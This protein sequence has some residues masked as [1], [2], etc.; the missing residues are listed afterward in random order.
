M[1][2]PFDAANRLAKAGV[3]VFYLELPP[4]V[5]GVSYRVLGQM[6]VLL[7]KG[8]TRVQQRC[9]LYHEY[10]HL[11]LFG[12]WIFGFHVCYR[13]KLREGTIETKVHRATAEALVPIK[14]LER[15]WKRGW[16]I[17]ELADHFDVTE[18]VIEDA[19]EYFVK[20]REP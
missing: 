18:E 8:L 11:K 10:F 1:A 9:T 4:T 19:I 20:R 6:V 16:W 12:G 15:L 3:H 5:R 13:D 17:D 7:N 14:S 2:R